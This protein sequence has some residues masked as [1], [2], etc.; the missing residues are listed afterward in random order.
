MTRKDFWA[1]ALALKY[2][3]RNDSPQERKA[4][5]EDF[6]YMLVATNPRFDKD[7][8]MSACGVEKEGA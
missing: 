5:A 2:I 4:K 1:I 3:T 7:K 6:A 8:F